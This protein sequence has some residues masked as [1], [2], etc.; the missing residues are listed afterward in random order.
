MIGEAVRVV[1][2]GVICGMALVAA[3]G[4]VLRRLLFGV[5]EVDPWSYAGAAV[6]VIGVSA[7][8]AL[9]PAWRASRVEAAR[10]LAGE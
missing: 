5:S 6:L 2:I 7:A 4:S 1:G 8:A 9:W 3:F 10:V